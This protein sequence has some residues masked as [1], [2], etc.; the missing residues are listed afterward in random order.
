MRAL[1]ARHGSRAI[2]LI[3]IAGIAVTIATMA[4]DLLRG[5]GGAATALHTSAPSADT[6]GLGPGSPAA[7]LKTVMS[8]HLF[9]LARPVAADG[10]ENDIDPVT[11]T[12]PMPEFE[13][14]A[15]TVAA[16]PARSN[17]ILS[18]DGKPPSLFRQG[19][20]L[21]GGARLSS[22]DHDHVVITHRGRDHTVAFPRGGNVSTRTTV[23][24]SGIGIETEA[25]DQLPPS[26]LEN[27][28]LE[29][30]F[31]AFEEHYGEEFTDEDEAQLQAELAKIYAGEG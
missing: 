19:D 10:A 23:A 29:G 1:L 8:R 22:I 30:D 28:G 20:Q 16:V 21:P 4:Y 18:A 2:E 17:A 31:A 12:T 15:V 14:Q 9:G 5:P 7:S 26:L 6:P 27:T 24:D 13:L 3:L 25:A 11:A